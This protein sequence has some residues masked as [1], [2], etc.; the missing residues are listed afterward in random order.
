VATRSEKLTISLHHAIKLGL[1][2]ALRIFVNVGQC[3]R[4]PI[5]GRNRAVAAILALPLVWCGSRMGLYKLE[6]YSHL[7][8]LIKVVIMALAGEVAR[9]LFPI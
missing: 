4:G 8:Y 7:G 6:R 1:V 5:C 2:S 9:E 3:Q